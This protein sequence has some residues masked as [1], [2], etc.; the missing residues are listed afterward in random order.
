MTISIK[1]LS[2]DKASKLNAL[3]FVCEQTNLLCLCALFMMILR[4]FLNN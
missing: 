2:V 3:N 1:I 4:N